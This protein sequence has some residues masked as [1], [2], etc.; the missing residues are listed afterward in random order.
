MFRKNK[1]FS[2]KYFPIFEK[3]FG[4]AKRVRQYDVDFSKNWYR[5]LNFEIA[6]LSI[7]FLVE[8]SMRAFL[9]TI[10]ILLGLIITKTD[11]NLFYILCTVY[12]SIFMFTSFSM[13]NYSIAVSNIINSIYY[14]AV[15]YFLVVDPKF[16]SSRSSGQIISKVG[17]GSEAIESILDTFM[18]DLS[19]SLVGVMTAAFAIYIIDATI[20]SYALISVIIL[21][22]ISIL[23]QIIR[24][25]IVAPQIIDNEDKLKAAGVETLQQVSHIR[26]SFASTEQIHKVG[27]LTSRYSTVQATVWLVSIFSTTFTRIL[28]VISFVI[29]GSLTF[30]QVVQNILPVSVAVGILGTF[31]NASSQI[32]FLGRA[33]E[34]FTDRISRVTDL[35]DFIRGFGKQT[36]P[37]LEGDK[38]QS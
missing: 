15:K 27:L 4:F 6:R 35:F 21:C 33:V 23:N 26:S 10:P 5:S 32:V 31:L 9:S 28:F 8:I 34:R 22:S 19:G 17:R 25:R 36:Y 37:V 30:D 13:Y 16:H 18:F 3:M 1:E 7:T 11:K 29:I 24:V 14:S 38:I 20:G 2:Q 12:L